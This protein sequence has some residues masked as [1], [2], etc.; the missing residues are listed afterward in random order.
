MNKPE[1]STHRLS[2]LIGKAGPPLLG[3][4]NPPSNV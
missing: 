1:M 2:I 3:R 4:Q